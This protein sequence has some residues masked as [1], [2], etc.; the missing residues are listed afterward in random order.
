MLYVSE[1]WDDK[2]YVKGNIERNGKFIVLTNYFIF[3]IG[4]N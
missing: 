1:Q 4:N 3:I 2:I